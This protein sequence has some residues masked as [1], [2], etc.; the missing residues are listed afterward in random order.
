MKLQKTIIVALLFLIISSIFF[1][2]SYDR[3]K[4]LALIIG[5]SEY[6]KQWSS[7]NTATD[8][9]LIKASLIKKGFKE[10]DIIILMNSEATKANIKK[11]LKSIS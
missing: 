5:I 2:F 9:K 4:K 8:V 6:K 1:N 10:Q 7:L 3:N 11:Y